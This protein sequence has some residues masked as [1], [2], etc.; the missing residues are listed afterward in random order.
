MFGY[1][2][3]NRPEMKVKELELYRTYYCG[4]CHALHERYGRKGQ[5]LLSYDGTF[6]AILLS[7][8]MLFQSVMNI[9]P[10][11]LIFLIIPVFQNNNI[12]MFRIIHIRKV[13]NIIAVLYGFGYLFISPIIRYLS[14]QDFILRAIFQVSKNDRLPTICFER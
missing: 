8:L 2:T 14:L 6:L 13:Y 10:S 9:R 3:V 11:V 1:V 7:G 5:M 12:L 4:L